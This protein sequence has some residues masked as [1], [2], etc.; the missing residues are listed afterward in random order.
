MSYTPQFHEEEQT[1]AQRWDAVWGAICVGASDQAVPSP[2]MAQLQLRYI[3]GEI[4]QV[5]IHDELMRR[6]RPDIAPAA[7]VRPLPPEQP[8][9]VYPYAAE[10]AALMQSMN[11]LL[12]YVPYTVM[13]ETVPLLG[14]P[15]ETCEPPLDLFSLSALLDMPTFLPQEATEDQRRAIMERAYAAGEAQGAII[16][17]DTREAYDRYVRG[18]CTLEQATE[19]A[20]SIYPLPKK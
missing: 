2:E 18:E 20:M 17:P 6:Y 4:D 7:D 14:S 5:Q 19:Q 9:R 1:P 16:T 8:G 13:Y 10:M 15:F 11:E 3:A 12:P